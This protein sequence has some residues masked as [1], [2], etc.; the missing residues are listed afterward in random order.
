MNKD[1]ELQLQLKD[2]EIA[3][4]QSVLAGTITESGS[5]NRSE[6]KWEINYSSILTRLIQEAGRWCEHYASDLFILWNVLNRKLEEGTMGTE[7]FVFAM[8]DCGVH[9]HK[10]WYGLHKDV[11]RLYR[12]VWFLDVVTCDDKIT[13]TLHK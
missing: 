6:N 3:S 10:E 2:E 1:L 12:A 7:T 5:Y 9:H 13:M 4:L 8:Y 11:P